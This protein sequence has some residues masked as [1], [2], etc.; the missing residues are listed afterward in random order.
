MKKN[1]KKK[2]RKFKYDTKLIKT[3]GISPLTNIDLKT[4]DGHDWAARVMVG[5][6]K[7]I[8]AK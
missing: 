2:I 4:N 6:G 5:H 3:L 8:G 1:N 7:K